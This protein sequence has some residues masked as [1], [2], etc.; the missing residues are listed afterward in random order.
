MAVYLDELE[1][2]CIW[3]QEEDPVQALFSVV[4]DLYNRQTWRRAADDLAMRLYC[5]MQ[6]VGYA[7]GTAT[8]MDD[9]ID[10]RLGDNVVRPIVRVLDSK[11]A[12]RR[13]RPFVVTDGANWRQRN[14]AENLERWLL[15]KLR[16]IKFDSKLAPMFRLHALVVGTGCIRVYGD[17]KKGAMAEVIPPQEILVDDSEARYGDPPNIYFVR[18]PSALQLIA[19]YPDKEEV[20]RK[21][22]G[23]SNDLFSSSRRWGTDNRTTDRVTVVEAYSLTGKR[24]V[25]AVQDGILLDEDYDRDHFPLVWLRGERRPGGFWGIGVTEDVAPYQLELH[26]TAIAR[27]EIIETLAVPYWLVERGMKVKP[28]HFS[29]LIGRVMEY[30]NTGSGGKPEMVSPNAVPQD[31]WLHPESMK[32]SAFESRG[33]SQLSAQMLKPSGLNSGKALRAFTEFES[34]LLTPLMDEYD[35]SILDL[36]E[37]LIE[38]QVALG[39]SGKGQKVTYVGNGSAERVEWKKELVDELEYIIEI[40]PASALASTL[41]SRIEDVYDL[42]DLGVI[43][44]AETVYDYLEIPDMRRLKQKTLS[45]RRVLE[46]AIEYRIVEKGE[47]V[48]PEPTWDLHMA[49]ELALGQLSELELYDDVPEDRMEMLRQFVEVCR[50]YLEM[51]EEAL[52]N[53]Q[54]QQPLNGAPGGDG[55]LGGASAPLDDGS[56]GIAGGGIPGGIPDGGVPG[57]GGLPGAG[58]GFPA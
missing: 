9:V 45:H 2:R 49:I 21:S 53:D 56:G 36:C 34:E 32:K 39:E 29:N 55:S 20:I 19:M 51:A 57:P 26:R 18:Q 4:R 17:K 46:R 33:I 50:Q 23:M 12:R 47:W 14:L 42:R 1:S 31:L 25:V 44:D 7:D 54:S 13:S 52:L 5:D 35:T 10:A 11:L 58:G 41:S 37:L 22:I 8:S 43:K 15:G 24:H 6:Y 16:E 3:H 40:L 38:E 28:S 30:T 27:Q 48:E